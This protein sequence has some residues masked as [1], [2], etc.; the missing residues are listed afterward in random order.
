[1][2]ITKTL[3][4][5]ELVITLDGRLDTTTAPVLETEMQSACEGVESLVLDLKDLVY[6]SSAGL[7]VIL[8]TQKRMAKQG[9]MKIVHVTKAV[10]DIFTMT[11]FAS[12]IRIEA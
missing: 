9:S 1:M 6:I 2:N 11:G 10:M 4:D 5:K 8:S 3:N 12:I 7:R